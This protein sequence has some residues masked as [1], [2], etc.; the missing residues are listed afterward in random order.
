M[1]RLERIPEPSPVR[2]H[3][4][5]AFHVRLRMTTHA[6]RGVH[7]TVKNLENYLQRRHP[8]GCHNGH[9]FGEQRHA[10]HTRGN[11]AHCKT[12]KRRNPKTLKTFRANATKMLKKG[13]RN[14]ER[15]IKRKQDSMIQNLKTEITFGHTSFIVEI[16]IPAF[17]RTAFSI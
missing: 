13:P 5:N 10:T 9:P 3:S 17:A 1:A 12:A 16:L 15:K 4:V 11:G 6:L 2:T 7:R 8:R 14:P